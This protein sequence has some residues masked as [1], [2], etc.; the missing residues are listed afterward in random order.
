MWPDVISLNNFDEDEILTGRTESVIAAMAGDWH[1]YRIRKHGPIVIV[2]AM[3]YYPFVSTINGDDHNFMFT[4]CGSPRTV[5]WL[6]VT[7]SNCKFDVCGMQKGARKAARTGLGDASVQTTNAEAKSAHILQSC[8][9]E[10]NP[11]VCRSCL[12]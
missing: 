2:I 10:C 12:N 1:R 6:G 11:D 4:M 3:I 8:A 7:L 5:S 9:L